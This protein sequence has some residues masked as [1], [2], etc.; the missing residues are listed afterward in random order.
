MNAK[1]MTEYDKA[2]NEINNLLDSK[3]DRYLLQE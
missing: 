3:R 1:A 2:K